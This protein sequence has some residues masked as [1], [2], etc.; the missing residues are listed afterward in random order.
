MATAGDVVIGITG[1][2]RSLQNAINNSIK[3]VE[4]LGTK[5]TTEVSRINGAFGGLKTAIAGLALGQLA[6]SIG[7]SALQLKR[8]SDATGQTITT[9]K[10]WKDA[11]V[12][13]GGTL[14]NATD[15]IGDFSKNLGDAAANGG[16]VLTAFN[17]LGIGL[18]EIQSLSEGDIL[19][20]VIDNLKELNKTDKLAAISISAKIFGESLKGIDLGKLNSD[21]IANS[22]KGSRA[23]D[24]TR[25]AAESQ[26]AFNVALDK[27]KESLAIA[28]TPLTSLISSLGENKDLLED[29]VGVVIKL[30]AAF[31]AFKALESIIVLVRT[32]T[33]AT[34]G[35]SAAM[36]RLF[37]GITAAILAYEG[38]DYTIKKIT[39]KGLAD[40]A[41]TAGEKMGFVDAKT[42]GAVDST[43]KLA[44]K[45]NEAAGASETLE[46][47]QKRRIDFFEK[48]RRALGEIV[49]QTGFQNGLQQERITRDINGLKLS[50]A[51]REQ[52][53]AIFD[54]ELKRKQALDDLSK[55]LAETTD[56]K[57]QQQ[58]VIAQKVINDSYDQQIKKVGALLVLKEKE[59]Q[60]ANV[61]KFA[62]ESVT[63]SLRTRVLLEDQIKNIQENQGRGL[64]EL[65]GQY[66]S[67]YMTMYEGAMSA[68]RAEEQRRGLQAGTLPMA[69][70]LK[71]INQA[72]QA[73][74]ELKKK[75]Q[76]L[77]QAEAKR[78]ELLA[79]DQEKVAVAKEL[80]DVQSEMATMTMTEIER[81]EYDIKRAAEERARAYIAAEE[82]RT[83]VKMTGSE[84]QRIIDDY[85]SGTK[86]LVNATKD[87]YDMSR[88][89]AVGWKQA[90]ND[91][92]KSATDGASKAKS[93]FG[94]AM[95]GM[96]DLL[97][98]FTK[99]GEFEWKNFVAMMLE[100][101]LRAQIQI[102]FAQMLGDMSGSMRSTGSNMLGS[103]GG[104]GG[105]V[106]GGVGQ[107]LGGVSGQ[108]G[109]NGDILSGIGN[110][111][112]GISDF[113]S[114]GYSLP[115]DQAGPTKPAGAGYT[116]VT[117]I[118]DTITNI[119]SG[120]VDVIS[121]IGSSIGDL[122]SGWF[123]EGGRIPSGK[124]GIAGEAGPELIKGPADVIPADQLAGG[125]GSGS[126]IVTYNIN[127][128]DA[129]S[130]KQMLAA[131]PSFLYG[132]TMQGAKGIPARR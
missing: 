99:T 84:Q 39:G 16:E 93:V 63:E 80:R 56:P 72:T 129:M 101:L 125:S 45:L 71:Y 82:A 86:D 111:F 20:K 4:N 108:Q 49:R 89:W 98:D 87:S 78:R 59:T 66:K 131:D 102:I 77:Y 97:V 120:V 112:G 18:A 10:N 1:D 2:D 81:K 50:S 31:I 115:A 8:F 76:E 127:A 38:L 110:I 21:L 47:S 62:F 48:E 22:D 19:R 29:L 53:E 52:Y 69:E 118:W 27:F 51:Q 13:A 116:A 46:Q 17:K 15:S 70:Q 44:G 88:S 14:D 74:E 12:S 43:G 64:T 117:G 65:Q 75:T 109:T 123:A 122:F 7:N 106:M 55:K 114:A 85:V 25:K 96:E 124:F 94:K 24:A 61:K 40:W 113:F 36:S 90:M 73:Y 28:L 119:G 30:G 105:G 23:A 6:S 60:D 68:I 95:S 26:I 3:S 107:V 32:L 126:T 79:F 34:I 58:I 35:L 100:E 5:V 67:L 83:G 91:Y 92:V 11:I 37:A 103:M 9:I 130:F 128:V 33:T 104:T 121:D 132:V 54:L 42:E 41:Q 57:L